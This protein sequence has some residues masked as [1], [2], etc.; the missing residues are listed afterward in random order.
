L[1]CPGGG[2][3]VWDEQTG[4]MQSTVYG[5]PADPKGQ[6]RVIPLPPEISALDAG[7][8]FEEHGLRA[9]VALQRKAV[10][11]GSET[12]APVNLR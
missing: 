6:P 1:I 8:T 4:T 7:L 9:R 2:D 3:Y 5:S 10:P 11:A 12:V